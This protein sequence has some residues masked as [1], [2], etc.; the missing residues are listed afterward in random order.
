MTKG[1][2]KCWEPQKDLSLRICDIQ[3]VVAARFP[4]SQP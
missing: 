2:A 1:F 3:P 4:P